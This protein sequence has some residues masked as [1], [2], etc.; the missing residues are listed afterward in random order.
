MYGC[1]S[2]AVSPLQVLWSKLCMHFSPLPCMLHTCI[3]L[4]RVISLL[5][6]TSTVETTFMSIYSI[7]SLLA[8]TSVGSRSLS[9]I[10][11]QWG[12]GMQKEQYYVW[13]LCILQ[14][15]VHLSTLYYLGTT[16]WQEGHIAWLALISR[17]LA[18][19]PQKTSAMLNKWSAVPCENHTNW[20]KS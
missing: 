11:E 5:F 7:A 9:A 10:N 13:N 6:D 17:Q 2:Q 12:K 18:G 4:W 1:V 3:Y 14:T 19:T 20:C 15:A 16:R 8:I